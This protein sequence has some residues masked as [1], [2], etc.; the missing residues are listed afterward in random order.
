MSVIVML[1]L[2]FQMVTMVFL[3]VAFRKLNAIEGKVDRQVP[4]PVKDLET[5]VQGQQ[6]TAVVGAKIDG[7]GII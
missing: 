7:G 5:T 4:P 1:I 6:M 2:L 3:A